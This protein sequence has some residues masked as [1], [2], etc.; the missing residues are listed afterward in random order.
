MNLLDKAE[1]I[2]KKASEKGSLRELIWIAAI[3]SV[4]ILTL[5]ITELTSMLADDYY[6][7]MN[8]VYGESVQVQSRRRRCPFRG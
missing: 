8:K 5:I 2:I 3:T 1:G 7:A 4:F 6:Y